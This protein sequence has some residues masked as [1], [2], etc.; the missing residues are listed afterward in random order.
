[1]DLIQDPS[2]LLAPAPEPASSALSPD[3]IVLIQFR[4]VLIGKH[5]VLSA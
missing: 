1:M 4:L 5:F 3:Q 2:S